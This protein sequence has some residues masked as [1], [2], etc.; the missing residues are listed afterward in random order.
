[1]ILYKCSDCGTRLE[2]APDQAGAIAQC[3]CCGTTVFVPKQSQV[4]FD[5]R[6]VSDAVH[7]EMA[8]PFCQESIPADSAK[9]RHCGEWL[10]MNRYTIE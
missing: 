3:T 8:C 2:A 1:M 4:V 6:R 10:S 7:R 5:D 9:C